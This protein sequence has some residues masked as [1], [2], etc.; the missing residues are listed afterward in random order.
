MT[1]FFVTVCIGAALMGVAASVE[2]AAG[3]PVDFARFEQMD[4]WTRHPVYGDPSFDTFE[5]LPG[6]PVVRGEGAYEW[7][8]NGSLFRDPA[9]GAWYLYTGHY[10][11]GYRINSDAP[12]MCT[13]SRSR[14][15][16]KTWEHLGRVLD[17]PSHV[18]DGEVHPA[19]RAP[20]CMVIHADGRYHMCFDWATANSTWENAASPPAEANNGVGY[21]WAERPEGPWHIAPEPVVTTR[22]Q[23]LL[24]GK[25]RR[26]YASSII[27]R[28]ND[29]MVVTLTD[30]GP[31]F[32]W[33]LVG[34]TAPKPDGPYASPKLLLHPESDRFHPPLLEFFPAFVHEGYVYAPTTSVA[35]NRN[36][37]TVFRA[38]LEQAMDPEAWEIV[39]HGSVWH[40]DPVENEAFG[41]WGQTFSGFIDPDGVFRVMFPSRDAQGHGTINLAS[42]PWAEPHREQGF[43]LSGHEG[44]SM[45]F[46]KRSGSVER[47][48][49]SMECRG[50]VT[51][52]WN[53]RGPLGPD[54][55]ASNCRI[56]P[57]M[58]T[59]YHALRLRDADWSL[60]A[61]DERAQDEEL[62][63]GQ[64][65]APVNRTFELVWDDAANATVTIDGASVWSGPLPTGPGHVGLLVG[66]QSH[67]DVS[68]FEVTG[69]DA[70]SR[71]EYLHTEG[72]LG[73]AQ[74]I[75]DWDEIHDE[76]FRYAVGAVSTGGK[77]R[78]KW[79][80]EA[81]SIVLFAPKGPEY[82]KGEVLL[83]GKLVATIDYHAPSPV[84]SSAVY[85]WNGDGP[86]RHALAVRSVEGKLPVDVIE[87]VP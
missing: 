29:W 21:A 13:V 34:M 87:V 35:L 61:V 60:V 71:F 8:V 55:P 72:L 44:P 3:A 24:E 7:P 65:D 57:L 22:D 16:G 76:R 86:G 53:A 79:N 77:V 63:K 75:K 40:A 20:D 4:E 17:N 52:V 28:A 66:R 81:R 56:H 48:A 68:Q 42:R 12:S 84:K 32:G 64:L 39:Q 9:D 80:V 83:D 69:L 15:G 46:L 14:D 37:Q 5:R 2:A 62:G 85:T 51:F 49:L 25:Y 82:G 6:N 11:K 38:P 43:V 27:R 31:C 50:G 18:F 78:V 23:A 58:L 47:V 19:S 59:R 70:P 54:R 30:S 73:A 1:L 67:A 36:F 33:A 41:I 26:L 45:T 10:C 74:H